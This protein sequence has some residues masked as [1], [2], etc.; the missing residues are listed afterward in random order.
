MS[1]GQRN[2]ILVGITLNP[3]VRTKYF[4]IALELARIA[5]QAK[6]TASTSSK[7]PTHHRTL[8]TGRAQR[9]C[10]ML[11]SSIVEARNPART[12]AL[13][14]FH[15]WSGANIAGRFACKGKLGHWKEMKCF[16]S[17]LHAPIFV[18]ASMVE[19]SS[20]IMSLIAMK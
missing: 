17:F 2:P 8:V 15:S 19:V 14:E 7:I 18:A 3:K 12:A 9:H 10:E 16:L 5:E 1:T 6:Q 4:L 11:F 20:V 13:P